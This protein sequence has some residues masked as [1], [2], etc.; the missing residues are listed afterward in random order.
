[1]TTH[2]SKMNTQGRVV[3]PAAIR[4]EMGVDGPTELL[5]RYEDGRVIVETMAVAVADVQRI[6]AAYVPEGR[7]L[8]DELIA[9]RRAEAASE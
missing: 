3:I 7:S 5:F 9:E 2:A 1:M 8:V 6:V 4:K